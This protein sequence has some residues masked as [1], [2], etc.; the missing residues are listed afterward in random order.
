M[1]PRTEARPK[2]RF[3]GEIAGLGTTSGVRVVI[4]CW[5]DSPFGA[6]CDVMVQQPDGH[7][8]LV[9]P[10]EPIAT[11]IAGT[12]H[13]DEVVTGP[14][15][16]LG[17]RTPTLTAPGLELRF[18]VRGR[19]AI[20]YLL[21]A[22]PRRLAT[23]PAWLRLIDPL[24]R[25]LVRGVRTAGSTGSGRREYYGAYDLHRITAAEGRWRGRPLGT[26]AP[27]EPAVSFGFGSTPRNPA[28]TRVV[29]TV[30]LE[31][32]DQSGLPS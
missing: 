6:F 19:T 14:V 24:A 27:V 23:A 16:V 12:Y 2:L 21:A 11:F 25:R 31:P 32:Q 22:L 28:V 8:V 9:A 4:G 29:T 15:A 7:R 5:S 20:G 17:D 1:R 30:E 10:T 13:F 26:L 18:Q 3:T